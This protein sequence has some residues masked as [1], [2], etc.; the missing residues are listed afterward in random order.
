[1][2]PRFKGLGNLRCI[3]SIQNTVKLYNQN[4]HGKLF[5]FNC[6]A[7]FFRG[8]TSNRELAVTSLLTLNATY[9]SVE[10][11]LDHALV[12]QIPKGT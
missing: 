6:Q 11:P 3:F 8:A 12:M 1:M 9:L 4:Y 5:C 2:Y 10:T 7:L